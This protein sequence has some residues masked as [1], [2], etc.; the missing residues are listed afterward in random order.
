MPA[1]RLLP[2]ALACLL[3]WIPLSGAAAPDLVNRS[4][5]VF[6][7]D[8][9]VGTHRFEFSGKPDS[10]SVDSTADM[11]YKI[12]FVTLFSYHH[13]AR[14]EWHDGCLA[15]LSSTTT[16]NGKHTAV[17]GHAV[18]GG[19]SMALADDGVTYDLSCAWGFAYWDPALRGHTQLINPQDGRLFEMTWTDLGSQPLSLSDRSVSA[20][21]WQLAGNDK[22]IVLYYDDRD[23]WIGLDSPVGDGDR[24]L[25]YR[26]AADDPFLPH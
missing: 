6:I 9:E 11:V 25:R 26:P 2:R 22:T 4:F 19:F 14:E 12:A 16:E 3:I 7:D 21:A 20:H 17:Q 5:R 13:H 15:G 23:R 1:I 8:K 24:M 10:F 18:E